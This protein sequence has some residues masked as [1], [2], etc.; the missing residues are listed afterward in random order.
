MAH[1]KIAQKESF[2]WPL[3]D[4]A[5]VL[6]LGA[7]GACRRASIVLGA[8]APAPHRARAAEAVLQ[9]QRIDEA[10]PR[11]AARGRDRGRDAAVRKRLQAA[12][13]RGVDETGGVE[14]GGVGTPSAPI[15]PGGIHHCLC[16]LRRQA[17]P[18]C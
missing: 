17:H 4:V 15:A 18:R 13:V 5:V 8:A 16:C 14:S 9:G 10:S 12:A 2:D 3:A 11:E 6:D 7:D 1:L